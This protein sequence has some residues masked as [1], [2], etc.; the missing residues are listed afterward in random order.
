MSAAAGGAGATSFSR[1]G[2]RSCTQRTPPSTA[3]RAPRF[4][5]T[6]SFNFCPFVFC[7]SRPASLLR[8]P[9]APSRTKWTRRVPHPVLIGRSRPPPSRGAALSWV[10]AVP[11]ATRGP[12]L[13]GVTP[14]RGAGRSCATCLPRSWRGNATSRCS[15]SSRRASRATAG[16]TAGAAAV[17]AAV[18]RSAWCWTITWA[19][20]RLP[21]PLRTNRTRRVLHPVLIGHAASFTPY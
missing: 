14:R 12:C 1:S 5:F 13:P 7:R 18:G 9:P 8:A 3:R 2:C 19:A 20:A 11:R 17:A 15:H 21:P 10:M 6:C 16:A 4:S